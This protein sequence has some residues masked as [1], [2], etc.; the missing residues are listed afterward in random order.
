ML[1][2]WYFLFLFSCRAL[3]HLTLI[4]DSCDLLFQASALLSPSDAEEEPSS[5]SKS[6]RQ[7]PVQTILICS[8]C[9]RLR[10]H[11]H[12]ASA[13]CLRCLTVSLCWITQRFLI[14]QASRNPN[15]SEWSVWSQ[16]WHCAQCKGALRLQMICTSFKPEKLV[17]ISSSVNG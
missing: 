15:Q 13:M 12:Q 2:V 3:F 16:R 4:Y 10:A 6:P 5:G 8:F 9:R 7:T 17:A 11:L 14:H 1:T